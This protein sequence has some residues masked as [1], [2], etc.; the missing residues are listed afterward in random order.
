MS[1][2]DIVVVVDVYPLPLSHSLII[3]LLESLLDIVAVAPLPLYLT[4][5]MALSDNVDVDPLPL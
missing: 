4:L 3:A 1:L 5:I 2:S